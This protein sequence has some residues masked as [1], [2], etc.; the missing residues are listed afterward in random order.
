[1]CI[2]L[3][4]VSGYLSTRQ[5]NSG[6][7][8]AA[9][10]LESED[11]WRSQNEVFQRYSHGSRH[12]W[13]SSITGYQ[14]LQLICLDFAVRTYR[15]NSTRRHFAY[16]TKA[17]SG[18]ITT[19]FHHIWRG[20]TLL[21]HALVV[22]IQGCRAV[23]SAQTLSPHFNP[24]RRIASVFK[25]PAATMPLPQYPMVS[26]KIP[27]RALINHIFSDNPYLKLDPGLL[28]HAENVGVPGQHP[29]YSIYVASIGCKIWH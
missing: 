3:L 17:R 5:K 28:R 21:R 4:E 16:F 7:A 26:C 20:R 15:R 22:N 14:F 8:F 6:L 18:Y 23:P 1:M 29:P 13:C 12:R 19:P 25:A 11:S 24:E 27:R 2:S 9:L 10:E